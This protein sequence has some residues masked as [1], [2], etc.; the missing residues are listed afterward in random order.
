MKAVPGAQHEP[1]M[2]ATQQYPL[3]VRWPQSLY[4]SRQG[5]RL[6]LY[7]K[8]PFGSQNPLKSLSKDTQSCAE[9]KPVF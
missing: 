7:R 6:C 4:V 5:G 9:F 3:R 1:A 8:S 2:A